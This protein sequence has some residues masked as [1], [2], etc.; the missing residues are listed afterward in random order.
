MQISL[1]GGYNENTIA[2]ALHMYNYPEDYGHRKDLQVLCLQFLIGNIDRLIQEKYQN[3]P[4]RE[5]I[6]IKC[7]YYL[8]LYRKEN[9]EQEVLE[10]TDIFFRHIPEQADEVLEILRREDAKIERKILERKIL[11]RKERNNVNTI[12]RTKVKENIYSDSQNVHN[13]NINNNVIKAL[14]YLYN[15]YLDKLISDCQD[16]FL[17]LEEMKDIILF[18]DILKSLYIQYPKKQKIILNTIQYIMKN[19]SYFG[20]QKLTLQDAFIALWYFINDHVHKKELTDRL[21]EEM[22]EMEGYCSTG[23]IARLMN[24]IQGFTE[25]ENLCIRISNLEQYNA[26]I[27][28]YLNNELKKCTD[29]KVIDGMLELNEEYKGFLKS[30]VLEKVD[31]WKKEYGKD[32]LKHICNIVNSFANTTIL[33]SL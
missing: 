7:R 17:T 28:N 12:Q 1:R 29:E 3:I 18:S 6:V 11:E 5:E 30:K 10:L 25:D 22:K 23:H 19:I 31:S 8:D 15:K 2:R 4:T 14:T 13:K 21:L 16:K 33:I 32:I 26:V 9:H 24:V 27:K 20:P